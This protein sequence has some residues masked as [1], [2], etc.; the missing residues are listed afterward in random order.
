MTEILN[1]ITEYRAL[2]LKIK[3]PGISS[4]LLSPKSRPQFKAKPEVVIDHI[5]YQRLQISFSNWLEVKQAGLDLLSWWEL[6]ENP[7][8]Y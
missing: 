8:T 6:I 1:E 3:I 7:G 4:K 2:Q 5:F